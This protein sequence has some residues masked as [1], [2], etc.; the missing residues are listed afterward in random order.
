MLVRHPLLEVLQMQPIENS[1]VSHLGGVRDQ[2]EIRGHRKTYIGSMPGKII[3]ALKKA[4]SSN[5]VILL[6]EVDKLAQDH[7][8]DPAA[9]LLEVLDPNQNHTFNDHYLTLT[10]IFQKCY[11]LATANSLS[12]IP[13]PLLDRMK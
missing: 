8:G 6:D 13:R 4:G 12:R 2:A 11:S 5:P 10:M 7:R 3:M 1:T 9:A